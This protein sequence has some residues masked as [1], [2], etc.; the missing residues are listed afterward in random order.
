MSTDTLPVIIPILW[1]YHF[2]NWGVNDN[3]SYQDC[4]A[5]D[6]GMINYELERIW[7]KAV[8]ASPRYYPWHLPR[9]TKE[10]IKP[11]SGQMSWTR[12]QMSSFQIQLYSTTS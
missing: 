4:I 3:F 8:M 2:L 10:T 9:G 11:Q 7:K 5:S 6:G 1:S 12:P